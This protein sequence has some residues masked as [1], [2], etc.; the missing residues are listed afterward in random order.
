MKCTSLKDNH[1]RK[2]MRHLTWRIHKISTFTPKILW[3]SSHVPHFDLVMC[4]CKLSWISNPYIRWNNGNVHFRHTWQRALEHAFQNLGVSW[5]TPI[6]MTWNIQCPIGDRDYYY[7]WLTRGFDGTCDVGCLHVTCA[8]TQCWLAVNK[9]A[10]VLYLL[11][12]LHRDHDDARHLVL[13]GNGASFRF[14]LYN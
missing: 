14:V 13:V 7:L 4:S 5:V 3:P 2:S 8:L 9:A 11:R 1:L 12:Q 6:I 10:V